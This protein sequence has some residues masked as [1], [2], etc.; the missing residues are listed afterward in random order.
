MTSVTAISNSNALTTN[1]P[2]NPN[3][4][5]TN[6]SCK[7]Q[8]INFNES[9]NNYD[10]GSYSNLDHVYPLNKRSFKHEFEK[11]G[12]SHT[13]DF[14]AELTQI[15]INSMRKSIPN[16]LYPNNHTKLT[17]RGGKPFD[18]KKEGERNKIISNNNNSNKHVIN[19]LNH[20]VITEGL[21]SSNNFMNTLNVGIPATTSIPRSSHS[22]HNVESVANSDMIVKSKHQISSKESSDQMKSNLET[23]DSN[24][25]NSS[26]NKTHSC[27]P[28]FT[29][30]QRRQRTHFTSQQLQELEA[31]FARNRYPDMNLREEIATWTELSESRVRVWFKNRRAKWRKRERHLDVVLRGTLT[32][33]FVPLIR[34]GVGQVSSGL[35]NGFPTVG[36][37]QISNAALAFTQPQI[38][39]FQNSSVN[40]CRNAYPIAS[41]SYDQI[42][43]KTYPVKSLYTTN[44]G[45][46]YPNSYYPYASGTNLHIGFPVGIPNPSWITSFNNCEYPNNNNNNSNDSNNAHSTDLSAAAFAASNM[47]NTYSSVIHGISSSNLLGLNSS[48][49]KISSVPSLSSSSSTKFI[50]SDFNN[51]LTPLTHCS[52]QLRDT[53]LQQ[54]NASLNNENNNNLEG[55]TVKSSSGLTSLSCCSTVSKSIHSSQYIN[56]LPLI[57]ANT[58]IDNDCVEDGSKTYSNHFSLHDINNPLRRLRDTKDYFKLSLPGENKSLKYHTI[59]R[60]YDIN[61]INSTSVSNSNIH[62]SELTDDLNFD[63]FIPPFMRKNDTYFNANETVGSLDRTNANITFPL[64][65]SSSSSSSIPSVLNTITAKKYENF[66]LISSQ[67]SEFFSDNDNNRKIIEQN[68]KLDESLGR[69]LT[70]YQQ[71]HQQ[72]FHSQQN[73]NEPVVVMSGNSNNFSF[74]PTAA[75]MAAAVKMNSSVYSS[76]H[77]TDLNSTANTTQIQST[78]LTTSTITYPTLS[79][80]QTNLS[81]LTSVPETYPM[82]APVSVS[83]ISS[84]SNIVNE[85]HDIYRNAMFTRYVLPSANLETSHRCTNNQTSGL[86][87]NQICQ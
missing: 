16:N 8:K 30:R 23:F 7:I 18:F 63:S 57:K 25:N 50:Q 11:F 48:R 31:T 49:E 21:F 38:T 14:N 69:S 6:Q 10:F 56:D 12:T 15:K 64:P 20:N 4:H 27:R 55:N 70:H 46:P 87:P 41:N 83:P 5:I 84:T 42:V 76:T 45:S 13:L 43:P 44:N 24:T 34:A 68:S 19:S 78:P 61:T 67:T 86:N 35:G 39:Y 85:S 75:M 54:L 47:L 32:N 79:E 2:N 51:P 80:W 59:C 17:E 81:K 29:K 28:Q 33:P 82:H 58:C 73:I 36:P 22:F 72:I 26:F 9:Y 53:G 60:D 71:N 77:L 52:N 62:D 1:T 40:N 66:Q 37:N 74:L 3:N 65:L